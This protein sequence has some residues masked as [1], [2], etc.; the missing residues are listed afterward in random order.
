MLSLTPLSAAQ[1]RRTPWKNG[2]GIAIDI[3]DAGRPG[4]WQDFGWRF[5]RT[6]IVAPGPFSDLTGCERMQAVI[7]GEGLVLV[8]PEG[9]IDL[10]QPFRPVR[11]DGGTPITT[12]LEKGSVEV[13]NL[14]T[15]RA[16]FT[17]DM[18]VLKAGESARL[19]PGIH[20]LYAPEAAI[21]VQLE[22]QTM[23]IEAGDALRIDAETPA[24]LS[25]Q[26][27]MVIASLFAV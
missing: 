10:R 3:A 16:S 1:F 27:L 17:M 18:I 23:L 26:G 7:A 9:E 24:S 21:E 15:Q 13:I 5:S 14:F 4:G 6:A 11:Y 19:K 25:V 12:R 22:A 8:T 20:I 2:G